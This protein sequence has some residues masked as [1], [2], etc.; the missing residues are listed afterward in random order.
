M[1]EYVKSVRINEKQQGTK[2]GAEPQLWLSSITPGVTVVSSSVLKAGSHT[3]S[4][5]H[6]IHS[7]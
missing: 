6:R 7:Q 2:E 5:L 3:Q 4:F 1:K